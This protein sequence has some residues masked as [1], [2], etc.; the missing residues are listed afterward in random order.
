MKVNINAGSIGQ[1]ITAE[2]VGDVTQRLERDGTADVSAKATA[3]QCQMTAVRV[4][5]LGANPSDT[6]RLALGREVREIEQRL[7]AAP[8][9]GLRHLELHQEWAVRTVDLQASLLRHR[10]T[11]VHFSGHG[12]NAGEI[13]LEDELGQARSVDT[14]ALAGVFR[15]IPGNVR[16]VV[17]NSCFSERQ[18]S[19]LVEQVDCVVGMTDAIDDSAAI[20]FATSYYQALAFGESV[21]TAFRA[22]CNQIQLDGLAGG[23][24][25]RLLVRPGVRAEAL[26]I[27][28]L[29]HAK[30]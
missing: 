30:L 15:A 17:V 8:P 20:A 3:E 9:D 1:A 26:R 22:G 25:P 14:A 11:I 13:R 4:L 16:C 18:A 29:A 21:E 12:N 5:F 6:T 2:A 19:A 24:L 7:R 23:D 27:T 10:P 28:V